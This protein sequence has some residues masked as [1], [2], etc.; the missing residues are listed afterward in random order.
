MKVL[1]LAACLLL[2]LCVSAQRCD[3][4]KNQYNELTDRTV[5]V[6]NPVVINMACS[7]KVIRVIDHKNHTDS[8]FVSLQIGYTGPGNFNLKGYLVR[9]ENGKTIKDADFPSFSQYDYTQYACAYFYMNEADRE[10]FENQKIATIQVDE[11]VVP[12]KDRYAKEFIKAMHCVSSAA[13]PASLS[14]N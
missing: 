13:P 11:F 2:S 6:S 12:V 8:N 5:I 7:M 9:F 1:I 4:F 3:F 14:K 10:D